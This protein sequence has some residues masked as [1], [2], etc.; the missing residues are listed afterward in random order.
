MNSLHN[1]KLTLAAFV[2]W[3]FHVI[4]YFLLRTYRSVNYKREARKMRSTFQRPLKPW[5][6]AHLRNRHNFW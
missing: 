6:D 1:A 2:L 5:E 4:R 3:P